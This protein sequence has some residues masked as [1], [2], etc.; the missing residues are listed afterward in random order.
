M[1]LELE[2]VHICI[3]ITMIET[4]GRDMAI[5]FFKRSA[6]MA[7]CFERLQYNSP[8]YRLCLRSLRLV[9]FVIYFPF[10]RLPLGQKH[11]EIRV[12]REIY[13]ITKVSC[14]ELSRLIGKVDEL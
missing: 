12:A 7:R 10:T 8:L 4:D 14:S 13:D 9:H 5:G 6:Y 3:P 11:E 1:F 2:A